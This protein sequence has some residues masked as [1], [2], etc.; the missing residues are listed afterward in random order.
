[1]SFAFIKSIFGSQTAR[2]AFG[3]L[4]LVAASNFAAAQ[5]EPAPTPTPTPIPVA[6]VPPSV[7]PSDPPP[8]APDF[9]APMRPLPGSERVGVDVANQISLSLEDAIRRALQNNNDIEASRN[10][11]EIAEFNL[12]AARGVF[13]PQIATESYYESATVPTASLIG[14][15]VN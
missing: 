15:A 9:R 6:T 5:D 11:V 4:I 7:L 1:M 10:S 12:R 8:V 14:G 2:V 13:D 3:T